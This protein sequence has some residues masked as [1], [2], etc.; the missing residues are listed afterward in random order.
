MGHIIS[1]SSAPGMGLWK[2][3]GCI[4]WKLRVTQLLYL[5]VVRLRNLGVA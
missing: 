3:L 1:A 5:G 4:V 2:L